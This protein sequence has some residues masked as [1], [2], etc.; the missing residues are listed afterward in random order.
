MG[1]TKGPQAN[2]V[3]LLPPASF[4]V[5]GEEG[6]VFSGS[7]KSFNA[8]KGW[9]FVTCEDVTAIF[10]KDIFIHRREFEGNTPNVGDEVHFSVELDDG[11]QP[12]AKASTMPQQVNWGPI[13]GNNQAMGNWNKPY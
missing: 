12:V 6:S 8:E 5:N 10:G 3:A 9:G 7:V 4:K 2:S 13:R 11:G 1:G